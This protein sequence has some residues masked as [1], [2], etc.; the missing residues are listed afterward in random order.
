MIERQRGKR[1]GDFRPAGNNRDFFGCEIFSRQLRH[2]LAGALGKFG[3]FDHRAIARCKHLHQRAK[4]KLERKIPRGQDADHALGF[5]T[6]LGPRAQQAERELH[7]ALVGLGPLV[8]VFQ[9]IIARS[10]GRRNIGQHRLRVGAVAEIRAHRLGEFI[11]VILDQSNR[12]PDAVFPLRHWFGA[13]SGEGGALARQQGFE[14]FAA[15]IGHVILPFA[16]MRFHLR[17]IFA[18]SPPADKA[19]AAARL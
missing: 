17:R 13:R 18:Q 19:V 3:R 12:A 1:G 6:H 4:G 14:F 7:L 15:I 11:P 16:V 8:H 9:R 5:I 10:H 2:Q